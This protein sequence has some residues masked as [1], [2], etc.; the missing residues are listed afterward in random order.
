[1]ANT[2]R[3]LTTCLALGLIFFMQY[4]AQSIHSWGRDFYYPHL[5][6]KKVRHKAIVTAGD[7]IATAFQPKLPDSRWCTLPATPPPHPPP[8]RATVH[9]PTT[10]E[11]GW[12]T[13]DSYGLSEN[14]PGFLSFEPHSQGP[15]WMKDK[16]GQGHP[17]LTILTFPWS[18]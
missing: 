15:M 8:P 7:C 13:P 11:C 18:T 12:G 6:M 9:R 5:Q 17:L 1:M 4:I 3:V 2:N 16:A 14:L 10:P